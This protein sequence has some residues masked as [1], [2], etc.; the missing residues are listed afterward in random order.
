MN[1][2][3]KARMVKV[4]KLMGDLLKEHKHNEREHP[5]FVLA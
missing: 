3:S 2:F 5:D 1:G 4:L